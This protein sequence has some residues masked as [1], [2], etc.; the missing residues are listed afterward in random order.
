MTLLCMVGTGV[1]CR[2]LGVEPETCLFFEQGA[3][4]AIMCGVFHEVGSYKDIKY[5]RF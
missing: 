5:S 4:K 1:C 3:L 2:G